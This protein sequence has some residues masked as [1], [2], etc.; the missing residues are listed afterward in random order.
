MEL[1]VFGNLIVCFWVW[2]AYDH[3]RV[4]VFFVG[5][6]MLR[7]DTSYVGFFNIS[8][9]FSKI[10]KIYLCCSKLKKKLFYLYTKRIGCRT[11]SLFLARNSSLCDRISVGEWLS[12]LFIGLGFPIQSWSHFCF[13]FL[14]SIFRTFPFLL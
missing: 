13:F 3:W 2:R 10:N 12:L 4:V 1:F 5:L 8:N 6:L 7:S 11:W 9:L 14:W